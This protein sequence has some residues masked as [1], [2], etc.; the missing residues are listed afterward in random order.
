MLVTQRRDGLE[1]VGHH[2]QQKIPPKQQLFQE[3]P[4]PYPCF[5]CIKASPNLQMERNPNQKLLVEGRFGM[6]QGYVGNF[7]QISLAIQIVQIPPYKRYLGIFFGLR[8]FTQ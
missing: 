8:V 4:R 5:A 3:N 6:F 2:K 1:S 7:F